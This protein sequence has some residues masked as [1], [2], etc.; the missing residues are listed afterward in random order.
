MAGRLPPASPASY[1]HV[2]ADVA[3]CDVDEDVSGEQPVLVADHRGSGR[4]LQARQLAELYP[5]TFCTFLRELSS[6]RRTPRILL[7][8]L[9]GLSEWPMIIRMT[10]TSRPQQ[11]YD[12]RLRDLVQ[13][14]G[15]LTITTDS[16]S[17]LDGER[18]APRGATMV[19]SLEVGDLTER[20]LRQEILSC[21]D[22]SRSSQRCSGW[23]SP[24]YTP[25]DSRSQESVCRTDM[26]SCESCAP[27]T[28]HTRVSRY[29]RSSGSCVCRRGRFQAW[30]R[31][32]AACALDDQSC[33]PR[34]SP[35]RLTLSEVQAI[36]AMVTSPE[37]RHV[38]T[39][40]LAVLAQRLGTVCASPSTWYR[41]L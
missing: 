1:V 13:R 36:G 9:S 27:W 8:E 31:R 16:A 34:T 20:E 25:P 4:D 19:V 3:V 10:T 29:E 14:T 2:A 33:C 21:G 30:R 5:R 23:R 24:C 6:R 22:A 7:E 41:L 12:H 18:V 26:P 17:A 40:T 11:R 35:H 28:G 37:D 32:Q 39:G 38:P 15:D